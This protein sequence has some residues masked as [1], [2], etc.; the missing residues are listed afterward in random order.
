MKWLGLLIGTSIVICACQ[1]PTSTPPSAS[2]EGITKVAAQVRGITCAGCGA[3][4]E[5]ALRQRLEGVAEVAISQ[6]AQTVSVQFVPGGGT[7]SAAAFRDAVDD[8]GI[9]VLAIHVD[10]CGVAEEAGGRRWLVAGSNRLALDDDGAAPLGRL[11]CVSGWLNDESTP[12][13]ITP[14]AVHSLAN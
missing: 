11:M 2:V 10:A 13:R 7:F 5:V 3:V 14:T 6:S 8:A 12:Y 1:S 9:E 4:A